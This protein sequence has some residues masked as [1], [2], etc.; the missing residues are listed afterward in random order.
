MENSN[1]DILDAN[2]G[3]PQLKRRQMLPW[4][5]KTFI[6]IFIFFGALTPIGIILGLIG[7][8]FQLSLYGLETTEPVSA[9]GVTITLLF[10]FKAFA[11][12]GLWTEKN[13]A[14]VLAEVDAIIGIVVCAF[15]MIAYPLVDEDPG[16]NISLRFELI[17]LIP[18]LIK[19]GRIKTAWSKIAR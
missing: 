9:I 2:F 11:A 4:W 19:L 7:I 3:A 12:F 6:W 13:W 14:V 1:A 16:F 15:I 5:I 18:Y 8:N 17:L 10:L